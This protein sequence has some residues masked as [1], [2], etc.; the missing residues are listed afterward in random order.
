MIWRRGA[1]LLDLL[2]AHFNMLLH[3]LL[4]LLTWYSRWRVSHSVSGRTTRRL[5]RSRTF[6]GQLLL[7]RV[8]TLLSRT[9]VKVNIV[10]LLWIRHYVVVVLPHSAVLGDLEVVLL[11]DQ[12]RLQGVQSPLLLLVGNKHSAFLAVKRSIDTGH[13]S[14]LAKYVP[15]VAF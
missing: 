5:S 11:G 10:I 2:L 13:R 3:L 14:K 15:N 4:L 1:L 9:Q 6:A 8:R 7:L 12:H